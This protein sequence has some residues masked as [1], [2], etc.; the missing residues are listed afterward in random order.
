MSGDERRAAGVARIL[1]D[2][3]EIRVRTAEMAKELDLVYGDDVPLL[4]GVLNGA[5]TLCGR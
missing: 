2:D 4:V 5:I 3:S 1:I